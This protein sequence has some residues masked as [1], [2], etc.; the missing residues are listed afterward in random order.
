MAQEFQVKPNLYA[1]LIGIDHYLPQKQSGTPQAMNLKGCVRDIERVEE[2]LRTRVGLTDNCIL[3]LTAT[4]VGAAEPAEPVEKWPTRENIVGAFA[5]LKEVTVP[6][7]HVY[8]HYSGHGARVKTPLRFQ[9]IKGGAGFDEAL[10]PTDYN[11]NE[12]N[13]LRDFELTCIL[14]EYVAR[15]LVV[16]VVLDS[17]HS[18]GAT[19]GA[20]QPGHSNDN[21]AAVRSIGVINDI[22]PPAKSPVASDAELAASCQSPSRAA[23]RD[24]KV[25]SGWLIEPKGYVL[26]AACRS[27]EYAYEHSFDGTEQSGV[28]TYWLLDSLK[29]L[30]PRVSFKALYDRL[31]AKIHSQFWNQTPQLEGEPDRVIFGSERVRPQ[32]AVAVLQVSEA[33]NEVVLNAGQAQGIGRGARFAIYPHGESDFTQVEQRRAL[34]SLLTPGATSSRARITERLRDEAIEQGDQAVLLESS[35]PK[36]QRT[37]RIIP[38]DGDTANATLKEVEQAL[39]GLKSGLLRLASNGSPADFLVSLCDANEYVISDAG[40]SIIPNLRPYL[41]AGDSGAPARLVERL[42]HLTKYL[43]V[44]ELD[45]CDP[46][47]TLKR[48]VTAELLGAQA[49]YIM[50]ERPTP[51]PFKD[52][53]SVPT[54]K[55]GEWTFLKIQN[56]SSQVLNI[57]VLDLRPNWSIRQVYPAG[58]A[59]YEPLDPNQSL[60]LPLRAS[61]PQGYDEGRDVIKVMA[62][63]GAS[64][65]RWLELPALDEP[66]KSRSVWRGAPAT[67]LE[68][69][70]AAFMRDGRGFRDLGVEATASHEWTTLQVEINVQRAE[71]PARDETPMLSPQAT[72]D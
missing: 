43:N 5:W 60:L 30:G 69:F 7:D 3:K 33:E 32:H 21:G 36:A 25:E 2:F 12:D 13:F 18:G 47:S 62:T 54:L 19:R 14:R 44:H 37:L 17:C 31:L 23:T 55:A 22:L 45:N 9:Q 46:Y 1:L 29:S 40:N 51:H 4:D 49:D 39:M 35:T 38:R 53:L 71:G 8:I 28:L 65:F 11:H 56:N 16:T 10:V 59:F 72:A 64:N 27:S 26:L 66:D 52:G 61:L 48:R 67:R 58:A 34:V 15:E 20:A 6:G 50:G 41:R 68:D 42:I 24:F 63:L 70:L 57:T